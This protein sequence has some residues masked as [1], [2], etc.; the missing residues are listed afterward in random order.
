[1]SD[2]E[3]LHELWEGKSLGARAARAALMPAELL[4]GAVSALRSGLYSS[5]IL[6][7]H[8]PALPALA[9]GNLTVGGTGKTPVAADFA[10]R[11]LDAGARPAIVLRGYGDDEPKVHA[12]LIP[13]VRVVVSP[14]RL[15]GIAEARGLG[16]D[17]AVLDDAFQHRRV[18]R[19][20]DV[21]L[22]SADGQWSTSRRLLPAGP[23]RE[24]L[25]ALGRAA[26]VIV[27]RKVASA[28]TASAVVDAVKHASRGIPTAVV[29]LEASELRSV[30]ESR[31]VPIESVRGESVLAISAIGNPNA[32]AAQLA[33]RGARVTARTFRDHHRFTR[34]EV[35]AL[36]A[37]ARHFDRTLCTLKDAV[38]LGPL[39]PG[40]SP[41]WYVSQRVVLEDG[42]DAVDAVVDAALRARTAS[43]YS[44]RP[45]PPGPPI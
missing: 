37:E 40:P 21:V 4:F 23:W 31:A 13:S 12:T 10:R 32:F 33:E 45:G 5:G 6:P 16:C 24:S 17:V 8:V 18:K 36:A 22:V 42:A 20:G 28:S 14:N 11:L 19:V 9:I 43:P 30:S 7:S 3:W 38:K 25:R 41:L 27:T 26:L 34:D 35:A 2:V 29:H 44:G 1:M 15:A 39:W